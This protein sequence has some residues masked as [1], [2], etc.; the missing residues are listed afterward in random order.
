MNSIIFTIIEI[1]I[2]LKK[3]YCY[4]FINTAIEDV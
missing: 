3:D 1:I 4:N 2:Y